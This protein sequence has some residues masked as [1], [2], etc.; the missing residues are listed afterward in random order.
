[1]HDNVAKT[2]ST[3]CIW[4]GLT[5]VL[6]FGVFKINWNGEMAMMLMFLSVVVICTAAGFSTAFVCGWRPNTSSAATRTVQPMSVNSADNFPDFTGKT[7]VVQTRNR[8]LVNVAILSECR[9]ES[10][11]GRIFLVGIRQPCSR[12]RP[13][14]TDGIQCLVAWDGIEEYMVFESVSDYHNRLAQLAEPA[15]TTSTSHSEMEQSI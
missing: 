9:F 10:Q 2:M 3:V 12:Q 15:M 5:V 11:G 13:S 8:P 7:I 1:M 14:W 6:T 4:L